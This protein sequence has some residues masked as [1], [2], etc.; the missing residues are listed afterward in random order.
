MALC[1][2]PWE[3]GEMLLALRGRQRP[4][5]LALPVVSAVEG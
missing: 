2:E 3:A 5:V 1:W 4:P